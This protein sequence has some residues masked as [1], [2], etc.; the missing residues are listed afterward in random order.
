MRIPGLAFSW[1]RAFGVTQVKQKI[2]H[3]TGIPMSW[4]GL[5]RKIEREIIKFI[6]GK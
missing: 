4:S 1:K 3:R 6:L 5:E 2:S